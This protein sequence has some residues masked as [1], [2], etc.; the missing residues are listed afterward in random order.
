MKTLNDISINRGGNGRNEFE[1][2]REAIKWIKEDIEDYRRAVI[3]LP[4]G[5]VGRTIHN[6][7]VSQRGKWKERFNITEE[8][9]K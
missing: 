5:Q 3:N 9:L 8:D 2:K 1:L 6:F 7:I 4:G